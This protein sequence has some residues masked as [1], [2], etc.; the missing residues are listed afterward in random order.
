M[1]P[2][3]IDVSALLSQPGKNRCRLLGGLRGTSLR[4]LLPQELFE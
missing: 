1:C 2:R 3:E 4:P